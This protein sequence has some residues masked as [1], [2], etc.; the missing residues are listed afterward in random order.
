MENSY[1]GLHI[2]EPCTTPIF[3]PILASPLTG[4]GDGGNGES[5]RGGANGGRA[6]DVH[7]PHSHATTNNV[8]ESMLCTLFTGAF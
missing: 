4:T 3:V 6:G 8:C 5:P 2:R 1:D 7:L